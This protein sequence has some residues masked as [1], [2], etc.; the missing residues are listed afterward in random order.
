MYIPPLITYVPPPLP[1]TNALSLTPSTCTP[2]DHSLLASL[3]ASHLSPAWVTYL[4]EG[5]TQGFKIG[6]RG[7]HSAH[8]APNLQSALAQVIQDYL[9]AECQAGQTA[10]PFPT[11]PLPAFVINPLGAVP[12]KR[13]G[14]WC[15]MHLSHSPGESINNGIHVSDFPLRY[16]TVY[17]A[18]GSGGPHGQNRHLE[19]LPTLSR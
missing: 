14:K 5:L 1:L 15:L 9:A 2:L 7:N 18:V 6:Y 4:L 19:H 11:P 10:G 8:T 16:S 13:S 17:D 12:K 3:L